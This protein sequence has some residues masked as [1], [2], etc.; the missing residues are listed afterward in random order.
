MDAKL[1]LTTGN[2]SFEISLSKNKANDERILFGLKGAGFVEPAAYFEIE[3][4]WLRDSSGC[5]IAGIA[6]GGSIQISGTIEESGLSYF[7]N[8]VPTRTNY[9]L[10]NQ[11]IGSFFID[12][13]AQSGVYSANV[14]VSY[15]DNSLDKKILFVS[16]DT[17]HYRRDFETIRGFSDNLYT[18]SG[19]YSGVDGIDGINGAQDFD[20][21]IFG[22]CSDIGNY[23]SL[24]WTGLTQNLLFLS[25]D[26]ATGVGVYLE[27]T[28]KTS[29]PD[30]RDGTVYSTQTDQFIMR[31]MPAGLTVKDIYSGWGEGAISGYAFSAESYS[32]E[33]ILSTDVLVDLDSPPYQAFHEI[34]IEK[35]NVYLINKFDLE[36][37]QSFRVENTTDKY[38]IILNSLLKKIT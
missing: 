28:L 15:D 2:A 5:S 27:Y 10:L 32:T 34:I 21:I 25:F 37:G 13:T 24:Y 6:N 33:K 16:T 17:G 35:D 18:G 8:G 22:K 3:S 31:R 36:T 23:S 1:P 20:L 14:S 11:D 9:P 7:V 19:F 4:G 30:I 12:D 26:E 29:I 38:S